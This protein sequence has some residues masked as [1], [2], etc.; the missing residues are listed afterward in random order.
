MYIVS[1]LYADEQKGY[2]PAIGQPYGTLPNWAL[3][4]QAASGIAGRGSAELYAASSTQVCPTS[5]ALFGREMT[6]TYAINATGHSGQPG[7]PDNYDNVAPEAHI[8]LDRIEFP[9]LAPIYFD[10]APA[11]PAPG[12]PPPTR[13]ASV[14]DLRLA[15]HV[16]RRIG[17]IH[18]KR[19]RFQVVFADG[20]AGVFEAVREEWVTP[21]P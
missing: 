19:G 17:Y 13:T 3:V 8:R 1:R 16:S 2:S 6:R 18:A 10:S 14:I 11:T 21:L 20:A 5:R 15:E 9:S 12:A 4:V 7:D